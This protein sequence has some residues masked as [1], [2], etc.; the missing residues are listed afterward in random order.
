MTLREELEILRGEPI[1]VFTGEPM[2]IP[3]IETSDS[4]KLCKHPVVSV[5]MMTYNHE[6]YIREAIEGVMMQKTDFE[7]ELVI[8]EDC[9]ADK[10]REI[11]FEYQKK[12]PDRIRVLWSEKN[13]GRNPHPSGGNA[14]RTLVRCRGEFIAFCEGDDYW[15]DP[16]KLQKQVDAMRKHPNV[17]F[18][19]CGARILTQSTGEFEDWDA[20]NVGFD[21]GVIP[22]KRYLLWTSFGKKPNLGFGPEFWQMTATFLVRKSALVAARV[23][24]DLFNWR[25]WVG[26]SVLCLG[27][28]SQGDAYYCPDQVS[29]YRR[30][31]TGATIASKGK[32]NVDTLLVRMYFARKI[33]NIGPLNLPD[34]FVE[35]FISWRAMKER[36]SDVDASCNALIRQWMRCKHARSLICRRLFWIQRLTTFDTRESMVLSRLDFFYKNCVVGYGLSDELARLYT[37]SDPENV[38][39]TLRY[40][41]SVASFLK[42]KVVKPGCAFAWHGMVLGVKSILPSEL[43]QWVRRRW[44]GGGE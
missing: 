27:C 14:E 15:I 17:V 6:P 26:D 28:A 39:S 31:S 20:S 1:E 7:F 22:S 4:E 9:S 12:Y 32:C 35:T 40:R 44:K 13:L 24:Y 2:D 25:L 30:T 41:L 16:L 21:P 36:A 23:S 34:R 42:H 3:C 19:F 18:C 11:C 29:V 43:Y 37:E 38:R 10:T 5:Q 8:G 33:F